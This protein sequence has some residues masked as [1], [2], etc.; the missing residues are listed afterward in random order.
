MTSAVETGFPG[1]A[2]L[3]WLLVTAFGIPFRANR[4]TTVTGR[5]RLAFGLALTAIAVHSLFYNALF[6]D[7]LTWALMALSVVAA[8]AAAT[9]GAEELA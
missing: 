9:R 5:A 7:P 3:A 8:R 1:L 2:L 6:E 4:F